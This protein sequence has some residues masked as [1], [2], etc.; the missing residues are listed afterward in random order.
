MQLIDVKRKEIKKL[1]VNNSQAEQFYEGLDFIRDWITKISLNKLSGNQFC[2]VV[3]D[4]QLRQFEY[5]NAELSL[6]HNSLTEDF[7]LGN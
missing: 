4:F 7:L 1:K 3:R 6:V 5:D 2:T